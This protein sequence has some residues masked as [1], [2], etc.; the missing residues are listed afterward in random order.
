VDAIFGTAD[1]E[2]Q[3]PNRPFRKINHAIA[4][5]KQYVTPTDPVTVIVRP[6]VHFSKDVILLASNVYIQG[7]GIDETL[8]YAQFAAVNSSNPNACN[9]NFATAVSDLSIVSYFNPAYFHDTDG[10]V[11]F[12]RLKIYQLNILFTCNDP[13]RRHNLATPKCVPNPTPSKPAAIVLRGTFTMNN[14]NVELDLGN[15]VPNTDNPVFSIR[16]DNAVNLSLERTNTLVRINN[17]ANVGANKYVSIIAYTSNN[18]NVMNLK[19]M[20]GL[21]TI[22]VQDQTDSGAFLLLVHATNNTSAPK[23]TFISNND[24]LDLESPNMVIGATTAPAQAIIKVDE[25]VASYINN[26]NYFFKN[27]LAT[28][29]IKYLSSDTVNK[30]TVI[31]DSNLAKTFLHHISVVNQ[32]QVPPTGGVSIRVLVVGSEA[33]ADNLAN[34]ANLSLI[35]TLPNIDTISGI[36]N[37]LPRD[38]VINI[39]PLVGGGPLT[40]ILP[41]SMPLRQRI[42]RIINKSNNNATVNTT[43]GELIDRSGTISPTTTLASG[44]AIEF[45]ST[46]PG[47]TYTWTADSL[48]D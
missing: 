17:A 25:N 14:S 43:G 45:S 39:I 30:F 34:G 33:E 2:F 3:N 6:G 35:T 4:N 7:S 42:I 26:V 16:D 24:R 27:N 13:R 18:G 36:Y 19:S 44:D 10:T 37:I 22:Q 28:P 23:V 38:R 9:I 5:A 1:G 41:L 20:N 21:H 46:A 40:V 29:V 15:P 47:G 48:I 12:R 31:Q 11:S 32:D 8:V